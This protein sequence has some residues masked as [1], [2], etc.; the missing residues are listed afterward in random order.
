M[1]L[2]VSVI[3]LSAA[4]A[5]CGGG[6]GSSGGTTT[7]VAS[8]N[9]APTVSAGTDQTVTE[10]TTVQLDGSAT[11][12]DG[13][14]MTITWSQTSGTTVTLSS[15]RDEDPTFEAPDVAS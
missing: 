13:D 1:R 3:A 5:A 11:E 4:L 10:S 2:H 8:S 9:T 15:T 7:P 12:A 14:A 6:G